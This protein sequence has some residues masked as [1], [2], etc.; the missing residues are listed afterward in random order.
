MNASF[1]IERT[2]RHFF[3][4]C[5]LGIGK[6]A[7]ASLLA[8]EGLRGATETAHSTTCA[9]RLR[10]NELSSFSWPGHPANW[11][12]LTTN[13]SSRKW[14]A[15]IPPSVIQGQRYAFI[16][17]DAAVLGPRF[18]FS[19]HGQ[20]GAELSDRLPYLSQ[21]VDDIAVVKSLHTDHFN[22][23]PAQ[24]FMTTGSGILGAPAWA[25]G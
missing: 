5:G 20:S 22:H 23:A 2:R 8:R 24:L 19:Q 18:P 1:L 11:N 21:I 15:S 12:S 10:P 16:Q 7:L 3:Q 6:M 9:T 13:P 4:D 25:P 17:P 14:K